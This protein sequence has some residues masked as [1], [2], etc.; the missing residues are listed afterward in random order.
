MCNVVVDIDL[1][2]LRFVPNQYKT[3]EM[4]KKAVDE[5]P[6]A[7]EFIPDQYKIAEM[8]NE[9]V[10]IDPDTLKFVPDWFVT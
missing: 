4:Y 7:L 9:A 1:E 5:V 6:Y 10:H 2:T 8:C 3:S